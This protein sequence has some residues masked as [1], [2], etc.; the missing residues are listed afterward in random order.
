MFVAPIFLLV[1]VTGALYVFRTELTEL[2]D[3]SIL[4]VAP[5][6]KRM[7]YDELFAK[8][9]REV[10]GEEIEAIVVRAEPDRSVRFVGHAHGEGEDD[11]GHL[12]IYM[13]PYTGEVLG[14]RV[15]EEDFFAIVLDLH[16]TLMMGTPGRVLGELATSWG[17]L[18]LASGIYL[19][20]PRGKK[21]VGVWI[22]RLS[23]KLYAVLRDWHAVAGFYLVPIAFLIIFT[24]MFFTVIWGTAFNTT[25]KNAG[26][27]PMEWFSPAKSTP[28]S[29]N[30]RPA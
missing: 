11:H 20:W 12:H 1:T 8:A 30:A 13:N 3:R 6:E 22:P 7:S 4:F 26:H 23:G 19:W 14:E 27:W 17:L 29:E 21:N 28:P 15:A 25:V 5:S 18:L 2:R 24:G 10:N 9:L 16:R